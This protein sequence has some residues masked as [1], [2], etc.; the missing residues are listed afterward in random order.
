MKIFLPKQL[1]DYN[2]TFLSHDQEISNVVGKCRVDLIVLDSELPGKNGLYWLDWIKH[3]H[4]R[5]PVILVSAKATADERLKGLVSGAL[6]YLSKPF[7]ARELSIRIENIFRRSLSEGTQKTIFIGNIELDFKTNRIDK[8]GAAS[9]LTQMESDIL[10]LL[11]INAGTTVSRDEIMEQIRGIKHNPLDRSIDIHINKIRK[12]LEASPS[13]IRT[14]RGK[15]YS[16]QLYESDHAN[17]V[18]NGL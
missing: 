14:V 11:Y 18:H 7:H 6:D 5:I 16:L 4:P 2:L 13:L 9:Y 10:K 3:F 12:K 1:P 17:R 8:D 15:G